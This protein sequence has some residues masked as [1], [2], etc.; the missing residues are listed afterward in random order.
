MGAIQGA[1]G[2]EAVAR[3]L[4][5]AIKKGEFKAHEAVPS[6][7]V[8][9]ERW[10][11]SRPIVREGIGMLV[12]KGILTRRHGRGTFVNDI[13]EQLG[14]EVWA[15]MSRS[16]PY[17]QGDLLEFRHMLERHAAELAAERHTAKDATRLRETEEAVYAAF[18]NDDRRQRMIADLAFHHSIAE[19]THNPVYAY[20]MKSMHKVLYEHMQL[21]L[22]GTESN[23]REFR[24]V[25][26]QHRALVQAILA[27]DAHGAGRIA[28]EHIDFVRV[29]L[30]HLAPSRAP[31]RADT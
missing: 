9:A 15:D 31:T 25:Q 11:V 8:L 21:T 26:A 20:L 4:D 10:G 19:A 22:I 6:E 13:E 30:N 14:S 2:P 18:L 16:H 12:A 27:R 24:Q 23:A 29:R 28:A 5:R 17:I 3:R 1:S 7:R